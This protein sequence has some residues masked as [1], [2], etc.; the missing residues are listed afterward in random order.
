MP[1]KFA[2]YKD[3]FGD[4]VY[5]DEDD[6]VPVPM[7]AR[8]KH[9]Q[10]LS[11]QQLNSSPSG[12]RA[13]AMQF[14]A[15]A[16]PSPKGILKSPAN[17]H[18]RGLGDGGGAAAFPAA[19][20]KQHLSFTDGVLDE[21]EEDGYEDVDQQQEKRPA[22]VC[23]SAKAAACGATLGGVGG[24]VGGVLLAVNPVGAVVVGAAVG[25]TSNL[26]LFAS[27]SRSRDDTLRRE[28]ARIL[29]MDD[30]EIARCQQ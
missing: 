6:L 14:V 13:A 15:S 27:S 20:Y 12:G 7:P 1:K 26:C 5:I 21:D 25:A 10:P 3:E 28:E 4:T 9:P 23:P 22:N 24:L 19:S 11:Q 30:R 29:Q 16:S 8:R 18:A 17:R 2:K